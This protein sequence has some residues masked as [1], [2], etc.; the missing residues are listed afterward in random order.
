MESDLSLNCIKKHLVE[1][2]ISIQRD[3]LKEDEFDC[4]EY[5]SMVEDLSCAMYVASRLNSWQEL[6]DKINKDI[7]GILG[8]FDLDSVIED[9]SFSI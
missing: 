9:C 5:V 3:F 6:S 8:Y 4:E 1:C 7:F 2:G